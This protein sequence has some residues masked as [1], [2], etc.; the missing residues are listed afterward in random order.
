MCRAP[1]KRS[2]RIS[3]EDC[4]EAIKKKSE[5]AKKKSSIDPSNQGDDQAPKIA[6]LLEYV[7]DMKA[8]E[9]GLIFSQWVS[10]LELIEEA[11]LE[12]G[13]TVSLSDRIKLQLII[14]L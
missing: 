4:K 5:S 11:L 9:K 2:D 7:S 3:I 6:K 10:Y 8:D 14:P 12:N 13:H 1:F